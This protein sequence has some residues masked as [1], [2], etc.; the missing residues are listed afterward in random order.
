MIPSHQ[1]L[2]RG[3]TFNILLIKELFSDQFLEI[4]FCFETFGNLKANTL[5][6]ENSPQPVQRYFPPSGHRAE[7]K[8]LLKILFQEKLFHLFS[9]FLLDRI[10]TKCTRISSAGFYLLDRRVRAESAQPV[11]HP[12]SWHI[13]HFLSS[14]SRNMC[15]PYWTPLLGIFLIVFSK[16]CSRDQYF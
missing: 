14:Q 8:I 15:N 3:F 2:K 13:S 4:M 9:T 1:S 11:M 16:I 10:Q 12:V 5:F 7:E 6:C